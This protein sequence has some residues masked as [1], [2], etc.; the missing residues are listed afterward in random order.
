MFENSGK[1]TPKITEIHPLEISQF[2]AELAWNVE[3]IDEL[4]D[5]VV[6]TIYFLREEGNEFEI[7]GSTEG[8]F[9]ANCSYFS[10]H[11]A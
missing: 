4:Y 6:E 2:A 7:K 11:G 3:E 9:L 10:K 8:W 5:P 1:L